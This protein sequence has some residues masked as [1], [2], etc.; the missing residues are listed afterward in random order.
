[1]DS[2]LAEVEDEVEPGPEEVMLDEEV[3][4]SVDEAVVEVVTVAVVTAEVEVDSVV[5]VV[6]VVVTEV[7]DSPHLP[8]VGPPGGSRL[9]LI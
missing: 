9:P 5:V 8:L 3:V 7:V 6:S 2:R 4:A 1:V